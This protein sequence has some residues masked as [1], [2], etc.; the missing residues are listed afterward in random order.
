[1]LAAALWCAAVLAV[2]GL[3]ARFPRSTWPEQ[4]GLLG[5]LF[6]FAVAGGWAVGAAGYAL[7]RAG[8][9]IDRIRE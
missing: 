7:A 2:G 5:G 1:M 6:G 4:L 8:W 9:L 3:F